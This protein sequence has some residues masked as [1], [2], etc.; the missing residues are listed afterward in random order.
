MKNYQKPQIDILAMLSKETISSGL[1]GWLEGA[2][3][4]F[5]EAGITTYVIES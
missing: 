4:E 2:G 5:S 1:N 3:S